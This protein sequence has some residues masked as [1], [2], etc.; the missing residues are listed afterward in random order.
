M[1]AISATA[2]SSTLCR[3][4]RGSRIRRA[5][6][7]AL[8]GLLQA[9]TVAG[10]VETQGGHVDDGDVE[11]VEGGGGGAGDPLQTLAHPVA[12]VLGGEEQHGAASGGAV[13]AQAW[14]AGG[15]GDGEIER[16]QGFAALGLAADDAHGLLGPT[17]CPPSTVAP[18]G[19][20]RAPPAPVSGSPSPPCPLLR[21]G[22][23]AQ[24]LHEELLVENLAVLLGAGGEQHVTHDG[25]RPGV[26]AG[27][28]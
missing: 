22:G 25:K 17:A 11:F 10:L 2:F 15:H 28:G 27:V 20:P 9:L 1:G 16:E 13:V 21:R 19:D 24:D 6:F 8:H 3:R 23:L 12:G 26:A 5:R 14:D 7:D 18:G 4:T